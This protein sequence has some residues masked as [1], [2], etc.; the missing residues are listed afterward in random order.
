MSYEPI[1]YTY[2]ADYHCTS[3]A[4][5]RFGQDDRGYVTEG[6]QDS[7]GNYVNVVSYF[8]EWWDDSHNMGDTLVCSDCGYECATIDPTDG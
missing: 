3:C 1:A 7:E 2:E 5:T 8:D 4:T 6:A